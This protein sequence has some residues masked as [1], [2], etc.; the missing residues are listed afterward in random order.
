MALKM[1]PY[2]ILPISSKDEA[3]SDSAALSSANKFQAT[4]INDLCFVFYVNMKHSKIGVVFSDKFYPLAQ[5]LGLTDQVLT[6]NFNELIT[7]QVNALKGDLVEEVLNKL[8]KAQSA[9]ELVQQV[10][11]QV[12]QP[13]SQDVV[14]S[15]VL[16]Q[17]PECESCPDE[18]EL[19]TQV[20]KQ[21]PKCDG[22]VGADDLEIQLLKMLS[23]RNLKIIN[24][25]SD[26]DASSA[27]L[28][29]PLLTSAEVV[30]EASLVTPT[31]TPRQQE[32]LNRQAVIA[33]QRLL[34]ANT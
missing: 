18:A 23:D 28:E 5:R 15:E 7:E 34:N 12:P 10:L 25:E 21:V 2:L 1:Q 13:L 26:V 19:V 27:T 11:K 30:E 33:Q 9:E 14:V 16:K 3:Q 24:N 17:V 32:V 29:E 20:L 8:P 6:M 22:C 4:A 31:M